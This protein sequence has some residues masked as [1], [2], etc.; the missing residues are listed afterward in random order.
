MNAISP[1]TLVGLTRNHPIDLIDVRTTAEFRSVH[2]PDARSLPLDRVTAD[3]VRSSRPTDA[4]G[5]TYVICKSGGRSKQAIDRLARED[6]S[7]ELTRVEGGT[8]AAI[9][10]GVEVVRG[11]QTMSLERQVRIAAG[12]LVAVGTAAGG[13][14]TPWALVVPAFVGCGLV[15]AGLTGTCGM[16]MMLAR[17]PW[18]R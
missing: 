9:E 8:D 17:M 4:Q 1:E 18:N 5:P 16:G 14:V 11:R 3:A 7:L 15:F 6:P 10:R 2:L 12:A 13:F